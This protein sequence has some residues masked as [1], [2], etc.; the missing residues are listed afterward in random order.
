MA[1]Q[2]AA[3]VPK[4]AT[5]VVIANGTGSDYVIRQVLNSRKVGAFFIMVEEPGPSVENQAAAGTS[6]CTLVHVI[7][8]L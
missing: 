3:W 7:V 5:S 2:A 4:S 1:V 6:D 8:M